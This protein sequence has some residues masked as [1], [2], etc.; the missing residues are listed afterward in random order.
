MPSK[1]RSTSKALNPINGHRNVTS[2]PSSLIFMRSAYVHGNI[3]TNSRYEMVKTVQRIAVV[4]EDTESLIQ[5]QEN[6][7]RL[8]YRIMVYCKYG[9]T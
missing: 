7:P 3:K 2:L 6:A 1:S 8:P 5:A 4:A 9:M